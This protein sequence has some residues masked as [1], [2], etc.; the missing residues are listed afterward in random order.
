MARPFFNE[1]YD[2]SYLR[3]YGTPLLIS[4]GHLYR[5]HSSIGQGR[6]VIGG[7]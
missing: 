5:R 4:H 7:H 3:I 1:V 6:L 2:R